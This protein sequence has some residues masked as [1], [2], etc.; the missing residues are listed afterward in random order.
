MFW[1]QYI[2]WLEIL[3]SH[4]LLTLEVPR[5]AKSSGPGWSS[6]SND[7]WALW[8]NGSYRIGDPIS[9]DSRGELMECPTR[10]ITINPNV[11]EQGQAIV[12]REL[13]V[14]KAISGRLLDLVKMKWLTVRHQVI[15]QPE[16]PIVSWDLSDPPS[17]KVWEY[18][19]QYRVRWTWYIWSWALAK[20]ESIGKLHVSMVQTSEPP[21]NLPLSLRQWLSLFKHLWLHG[22][23]W[24]L[25]TSYWR[26]KK[27]GVIM[28]C[29][30][31]QNYTIASLS[32]HSWVALKNGG[33]VNPL[34]GKFF[35]QCAWSS[36]LCGRKWGS[37]IRIKWTSGQ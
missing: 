10:R 7:T 20:P 26:G 12:S 14:W 29:G 21:L 31:C 1:K 16:L 4:W 2:S 6:S 35:G 28:V 18:Q 8:S 11:L 23:G 9:K 25:M 34:N 24:F 13:Y 22:F 5:A 33:R 30:A 15:R 37:K 32:P 19:Q 3:L 17:P 27:A 36:I